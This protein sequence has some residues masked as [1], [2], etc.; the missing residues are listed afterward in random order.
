MSILALNDFYKFDRLG[1]RTMNIIKSILSVGGIILPNNFNED[2]HYVCRT[3]DVM[4][5]TKYPVKDI[6]DNEVVVS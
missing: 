2:L 4:H 3:F 1:N 5:P 6:N